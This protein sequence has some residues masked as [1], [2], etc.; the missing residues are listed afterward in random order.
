MKDNTE[1]TERVGSLV[2]MI[3]MFLCIIFAIVARYVTMRESFSSGDFF[4]GI[5][6]TGVV[7]VLTCT[8]IDEARGGPGEVVRRRAKTGSKPTQSAKRLS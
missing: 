7:V 3:L 4:M 8:A 5:L 6:L 2:F 1:K